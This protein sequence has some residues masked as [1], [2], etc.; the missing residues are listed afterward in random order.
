MYTKSLHVLVLMV[1]VQAQTV[2]SVYE[3]TDKL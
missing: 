1:S 3:V 2:L